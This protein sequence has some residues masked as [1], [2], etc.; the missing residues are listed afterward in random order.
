[1]AYPNITASQYNLLDLIWQDG[2]GFASSRWGGDAIDGIWSRYRMWKAYFTGTHSDS[3][4]EHRAAATYNVKVTAT[5]KIGV[6][7]VLTGVASGAGLLISA[8]SGEFTYTGTG[9][10]PLYSGV[11]VAGNIHTPVIR[12]T[13][14]K[15]NAGVFIDLS[16]YTLSYTTTNSGNY[17]FTLNSAVATSPSWTVYYDYLYRL[18]SPVESGCFVIQQN[19]TAVNAD[20]SA[21]AWTSMSAT[22]IIY[23]LGVKSYSGNSIDGFDMQS[24]PGG[25]NYVIVWRY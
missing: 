14:L 3:T 16:L 24:L 23:T 15:N 12:V 8:A 13:A 18:E 5:D 21:T 10:D 20:N 7:Q 25:L 22:D 9:Y 1:M 19:Q 2:I 11:A 4:L 6:A 17:G